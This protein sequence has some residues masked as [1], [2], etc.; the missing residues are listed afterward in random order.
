M[1][2]Q[3]TERASK[4]KGKAPPSSAM[5]KKKNKKR[6]IKANTPVAS[7]V[8][9]L[10]VEGGIGCCQ[11]FPFPGFLLLAS[12]SPAKKDFPSRWQ[13]AGTDLLCSFS[14]LW[15]HIIRHSHRLDTVA[16]PMH[17]ITHFVQWEEEKKRALGGLLLVKH[18]LPHEE[19]YWAGIALS[20]LSRPSL[21][22]D[23]RWAHSLH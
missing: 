6:K 2:R 10:Q 12:L 8:S 16:V 19:R 13:K 9:S 21:R 1:R 3:R 11:L 20:P 5:R 18:C 15:S 17:S 14:Q 7:V 23:G 4:W 22:K